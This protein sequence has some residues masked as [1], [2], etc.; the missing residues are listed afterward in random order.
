[1]TKQLEVRNIWQAP[2]Y[3]EISLTLIDQETQREYRAH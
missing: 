2:G 3:R 1:M